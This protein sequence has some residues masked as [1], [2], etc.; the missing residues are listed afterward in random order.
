MH[1]HV[2][3]SFK[4][5]KT[6]TIKLAK[7]LIPEKY[8]QEIEFSIDKTPN[9]SFKLNQF[10]YANGSGTKLVY[11]SSFIGDGTPVDLSGYKKFCI[12]RASDNKIVF[13]GDI[14]FVTESDIQGKDKLYV[15]D[16]SS[17]KEN[18]EFYIWVDGLG[19]SYTFR[20]G[21]QVARDFFRFALKGLYFQ[22][23]G[24]AMEEPYADK[25]PR[26]AAPAH[27]KVYVTKKNIVHPWFAGHGDIII[28]ARQ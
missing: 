26:P 28:D 5:G 16:I 15:L 3:Q 6:Y 10:G 14:N 17:F 22:R 12:K 18:G 19:R 4:T 2:K 1:L 20:N 24:I 7:G 23:C 21:D 11:L 8:P 13:N 25:W 27:S 9:P